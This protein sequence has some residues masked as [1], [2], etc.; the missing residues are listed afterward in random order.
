[1][2][3]QITYSPQYASVVTCSAARLHL[4][5]VKK[6]YASSGLETRLLFSLFQPPAEGG[7]GEQEQ[8]Q[9][10]RRDQEIEPD[11]LEAAFF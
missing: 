1:M 11:Q 7:L 10:A 8:G 9:K 2:S 4:S 5:E 6:T 3:G